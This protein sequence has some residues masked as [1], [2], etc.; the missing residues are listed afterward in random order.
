MSRHPE[1]I[2]AR[3]LVFASCLV[4]EVGFVRGGS[5]STGDTTGLRQLADDNARLLEL[6][7]QPTPAELPSRAPSRAL[8]RVVEHT[9]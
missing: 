7:A 6:L 2:R 1:L 8:D 5:R 9:L 4:R 3:A